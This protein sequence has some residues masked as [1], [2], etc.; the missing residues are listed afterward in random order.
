MHCCEPGAVQ[1]WADAAA[2]TGACSVAGELAADAVIAAVA[3]ADM[4]ASQLESLTQLVLT[5]AQPCCVAQQ[6]AAGR[7]AQA[8]VSQSELWV[9]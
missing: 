5:L 2:G 4:Q 9:P 3:A 6:A 7:T 8:P 1:H